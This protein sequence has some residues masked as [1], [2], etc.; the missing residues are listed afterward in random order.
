MSLRLLFVPSFFDYLHFWITRIMN[1][2]V[3]P[4][5]L[6]HRVVILPPFY[7]HDSSPFKIKFLLST[8]MN[9]LGF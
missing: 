7:E 3:K 2:Q 9:P 6:K 8:H 1:T 5:G 4:E